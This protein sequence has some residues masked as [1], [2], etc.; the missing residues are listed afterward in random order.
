MKKTKTEEVKAQ[1]RT[2]RGRFAPA[3]AGEPA[4]LGDLKE[5]EKFLLGGT[6]YYVA[7]LGEEVLCMSLVQVGKSWSGGEYRS[8]TPDTKVKRIRV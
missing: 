2:P 1:P 6:R 4:V 3:V 7:V 5:G 8:F